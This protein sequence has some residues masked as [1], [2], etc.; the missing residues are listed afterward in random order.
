MSR[1]VALVERQAD[2]G[3]V[4]RLAAGHAGVRRRR[5]RAGRTA[6]ACSAGATARP[7]GVRTS[8]ASACM[9]VAGEHRLGVAEPHVH[10]RLAA[11]QHVVVH[12]RQVVVDQRI[13]VDQLDRAGGAQAPP[14]GCPAPPARR[15]APAAAAGACRRRARRSASPRPGRPAQSARHPGV[16]R[17]LDGLELGDRPG[18]EVVLG[19]SLRSMPRLAAGPSSSTLTCCSTASSR[20]RQNCEQLGAAPVACRAGPRAAAGRLPS[21]PPG[22]RARPA[23]P[24]SSRAAPRS[25]RVAVAVVI[26]SEKTR[27]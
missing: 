26:G 11:A 27:L 18:V 7:S 3:E 25:G 5:A 12:A 16:E 21:R 19:R 1:K 6:R 17:G 8:N 23:R 24:R 15:P 10:G 2:A 20:A 13:G 22:S 4:D 14:R 9:R